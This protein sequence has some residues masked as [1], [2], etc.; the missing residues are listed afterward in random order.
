MP[1]CC[2]A[3]LYNASLAKKIPSAGDLVRR[4]RIYAR[5]QIEIKKKYIFKTRRFLSK[6]Y[7]NSVMSMHRKN[8]EGKP[9]YPMQERWTYRKITLFGRLLG[10]LQKQENGTK[11][12]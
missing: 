10:D 4:K 8:I 7:I 6:N 9:E 3:R 2:Q 1:F 12:Q 11:C 5:G